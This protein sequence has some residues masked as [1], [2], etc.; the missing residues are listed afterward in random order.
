MICY[1]FSICYAWN[2]LVPFKKRQKHSRM[3]DTSSTVG[4]EAYSYTKSITPPWIFFTY[5]T[6]YKWYLIP[7]SVLYTN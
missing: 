5:F 6:L 3:S 1:H 4:A 7:Q 2:H